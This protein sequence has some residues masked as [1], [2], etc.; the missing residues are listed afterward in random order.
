MKN[1]SPCGRPRVSSCHVDGIA[2]LNLAYIGALK[3]ALPRP[4]DSGREA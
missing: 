4:N 1:T 3:V 2:I